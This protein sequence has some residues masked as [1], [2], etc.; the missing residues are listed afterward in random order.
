[1]VDRNGGP[2]G[3]RGSVEVFASQRSFVELVELIGERVFGH[4][5]GEYRVLLVIGQRRVANGGDHLIGGHWQVNLVAGIVLVLAGGVREEDFIVG[6]SHGHG[7]AMVEAV[8]CDESGEQFGQR[9]VVF[10]KVG[11]EVIFQ[12]EPI[13]DTYD[14]GG[15]NG[16]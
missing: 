8:V 11:A 16:G 7:G 5:S 9:I 14:L 1:M 6:Q 12:N 10:G 4:G 3:E 13:A 2:K 15:F